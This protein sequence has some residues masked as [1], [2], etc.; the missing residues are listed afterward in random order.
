MLHELLATVDESLDTIVKI[1][2][3]GAER[4]VFTTHT[5]WLERVGVVILELHDHIVAGCDEAVSQAVADHDFIR[6][7]DDEHTIFVSRNLKK[8]EVDV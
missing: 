3:E 5:D 1:D 4:Q 6:F 2:I 7:E 8:Q